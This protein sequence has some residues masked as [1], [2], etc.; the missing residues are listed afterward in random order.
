MNDWL[1]M[2]DNDIT[3]SNEEDLRELY[4]E[5]DTSEEKLQLYI[6]LDRYITSSKLICIVRFNMNF[7]QLIDKV[8]E[9][10]SKDVDKISQEI[11]QEEANLLYDMKYFL[12]KYCEETKAIRD[13]IINTK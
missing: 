9:I 12:S 13:K 8:K 3:F 7:E 5:E 2:I 1:R 11:S 4:K 10:E 6:L